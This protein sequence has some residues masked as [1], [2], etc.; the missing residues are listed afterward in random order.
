[1]AL[2]FGCPAAM[3]ATKELCDSLLDPVKQEQCPPSEDRHCHSWLAYCQSNG[4]CPSVGRSVGCHRQG[5][6]MPP[7]L[8][9]EETAI[10]ER[11]MSVI[12]VA[13]DGACRFQD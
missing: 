12:D 13:A 2:H 5:L 9:F 6:I 10:F 4:S 7:R 8:A 1:M 11:E 3:A